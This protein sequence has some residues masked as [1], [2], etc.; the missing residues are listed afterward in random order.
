M[1]EKRLGRVRIELGRGLVEQQQLWTKGDRG[2]QT[3]TL[4]L[5]AGQLGDGTV[6]QM[7]RADD[8]KGLVC[9]ADDLFRARADV[10]EPEGDFAKH[11]RQHDL[12]LRILKDARDGP[13]ELGRAHDSRVAAVDLDASFEA[14][15]VKVRDEAGEC[16]EQRRLARPGRSEQR[17]HL[18][19]V[20]LQRDVVQRRSR[21]LRVGERQPLCA[22]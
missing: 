15:A 4:Q 8:G 22:R 1:L 10:L 19:R 12:L 14:P 5:A 13:G 16:S 9:A 20:E 2:R 21:R 7:L 11:A 18:A 17:H 6:D 3:D